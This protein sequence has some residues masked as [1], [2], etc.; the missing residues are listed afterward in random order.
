MSGV[1]AESEADMYLPRACR[2]SGAC[3]QEEKELTV[4]S[5]QVLSGTEWEQTDHA[6]VL[7]CKTNNCIEALKVKEVQEKG[8]RKA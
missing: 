6:T 7:S 8:K 3:S 4:K 1:D 5:S 2:R